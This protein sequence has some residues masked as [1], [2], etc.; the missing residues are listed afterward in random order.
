[1]LYM[2]SV[3]LERPV[4]PVY[5]Y[6]LLFKVEEPVRL[7]AFSGSA[8]RG[9]F[10]HALKKTTCVV[11]DTACNE[12]MLKTSCAYSYIFETPPPETAEKMRKYNTSPHPFALQFPIQQDAKSNIYQLNM[13]VYG[14]GQRFF[15]YIAHAMRKA[16]NDGLGNSRQIFKLESIKQITADEKD[17]IVYQDEKLHAQ[18]TDCIIDI[19]SM[20]NS[21]NIKIHTP[22]RIKQK[23]HNLDSEQ[24]NFS[25]LFSNLLRRIS[26]LTYFHTDNPLET[27]FAGLTQRAKQI[28]F[29]RK[30]LQWYDW[31]RY[32]S[33]QKTQMNMGGVI[34]TLQL[35][36][37]GMEDFWPYLWL[38]QWTHAGKATSMGLG[39]YTINMTSLPDHK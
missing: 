33:R 20:P 14:H 36:S 34:G 17:H 12:C 21:I 24:F 32:S 1:M 7:P 16:G 38:G 28:N 2:N 26:M 37:E 39:H 22:I 29:T 9:A 15:P 11:R 31:K 10:G 18:L 23:G 5:Q 19:P 4:L 13:M 6:Q 25:A 27:D 30:N 8:W 35:D 3:T